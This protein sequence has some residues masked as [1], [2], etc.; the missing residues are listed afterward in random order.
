MEWARVAALGA[1]MAPDD[2][3]FA[4]Q[5]GTGQ[6]SAETS[7][8]TSS[9]ET[10]PSAEKGNAEST[11]H[12]ESAQGGSE[13]SP[14][15]EEDEERIDASLE[16][17]F[18]ELMG[19]G[20]HRAEWDETL[21]DEPAPASGAAAEEEMPAGSEEEGTPI[22]LESEHSPGSAGPA[23]TDDVDDIPVVDLDLAE[24]WVE[25]SPEA[26][27]AHAE[28]EPAA[29]EPAAPEPAA[30]E[31]A[32]PESARP[33]ST[34]GG[35]ESA[36]EA[37][38]EMP[39]V[40]DLEEP[41]AAP[42]APGDGAAAPMDAEE[43][44]DLIGDVVAEEPAVEPDPEPETES[45]SEPSAESAS[46]SA[47]EPGEAPG[48]ADESGEPPEGLHPLEADE[49]AAWDEFE[50]DVADLLNDVDE[51]GTKLDLARAYIDMGDAEGARGILEE[52]VEEG[53]EEQQ[54]E[55]RSLLDQGPG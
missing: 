54:Q 46:T 55:A 30:P 7:G 37:A 33:E 25:G 36:D 1:T 35:D 20:D 9:P 26:A 47:R 24:D 8:G 29:P 39:P 19:E 44:D 27:F 21:A 38:D 5:P 31:P 3:L 13:G 14:A 23:S 10:S 48:A 15:D 18:A 11:D 22:D 50:D 49:S 16:D 43:L 28:A 34:K 42:T 53:N 17:E 45:Q 51:V 2:P 32:A 12:R 4:Q 6:G 40:I 41:E 52:V